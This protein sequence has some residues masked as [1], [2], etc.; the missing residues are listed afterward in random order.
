MT[1]IATNTAGRSWLSEYLKRKNKK[2]PASPEV[3]EKHEYI[4]V[5]D[6]EEK[7]E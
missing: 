6:E 2:E 3:I 1:S 7:F 5:E 4:F